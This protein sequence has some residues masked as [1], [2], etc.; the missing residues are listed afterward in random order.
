MGFAGVRDVERVLVNGMVRNEGGSLVKCLRQTV[1]L[2]KEQN[3]ENSTTEGLNE[4]RTKK[5]RLSGSAVEGL[6]NGVKE[7]VSNRR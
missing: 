4:E 7:L 5:K 3:Q 1:V 2:G 6:A